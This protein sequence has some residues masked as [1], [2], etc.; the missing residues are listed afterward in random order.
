M[1]LVLILTGDARADMP[2]V[3]PTEV[4]VEPLSIGPGDYVTHP[5]SGRLLYCVARHVN[6]VSREIEV[7]LDTP[8]AKHKTHDYFRRARFR[9]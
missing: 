5:I 1:K 6:L 3:E 9:W 4:N 8:P 2:K 7:I